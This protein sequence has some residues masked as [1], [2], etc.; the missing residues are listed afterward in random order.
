MKYIVRTAREQDLPRIEEIYAYARDFMAKNGNP[1]QWGKTNPPSAQLRQDISE[2]KLFVITDGEAIHG[3]FYFRI[4]ADPTY[5]RIDGGVWRSDSPY[6]TIHRIAGD[7]SGGILKTAVAFAEKRIAHLR[8]D[9]HADNRVMQSAVTKLGFQRR[10]IIYL[11]NGSPRIAY[12]RLTGE[13]L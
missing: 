13:A 10:G 4:G 11:A 5:G 2:Q 7:G 6:G 8:I 9:T 1:N 12:D 3:V